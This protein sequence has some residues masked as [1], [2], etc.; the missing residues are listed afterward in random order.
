MIKFSAPGKIHLLGEHA[1]VYGKPAIL[2]A[3]DLRITVNLSP[4]PIVIPSGVKDDKLQ[5][6]IEPIIKKHL[7]ITTIPPYHLSISSQIPTGAGL[8]SSAAISASCIAALLTFL[9]VR[10]DLNLVN[11]L[12][13][14]AEKVFHGNPSGA[15][16]STVVFGGLIWYR[17]KTDHLKLI[18]PL[19]FSIPQ[20]L[21]KNFVLINSGKPEEITR[22]M[23]SQ[24]KSL[25]QKKFA[26]VDKFLQKQEQLVKEIL[27]SIEQKNAKKLISTIKMGQNNLEIIGVVSKSVIPIIREVEEAGGAAKICGAG[28]KKGPAGVLLCYHPDPQRLIEIAKKYNLAYFRTALGVEGLRKE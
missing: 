3:L 5:K 22:Q 17:K 11:S 26:L 28:G 18:H 4:R 23:V 21:A 15:D 1:V 13:Y 12:T 27:Q 14:E 8:G 7:H 25:Y 2:A 20:K 6:V 16:N 19:P 9:R 10:W 24:V